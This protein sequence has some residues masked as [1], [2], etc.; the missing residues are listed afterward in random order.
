MGGYLRIGG[1]VLHSQI[2]FAITGV[3]RAYKSHGGKACC[4]EAKLGNTQPAFP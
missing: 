1:V 2:S 4:T 3:M